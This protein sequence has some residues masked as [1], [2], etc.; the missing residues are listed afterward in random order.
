MSEE[1]VIY[2][3]NARLNI[4]INGQNGDYPDLVSFDAGDG[5]IKQ[6]ATEALRTGYVP[7]IGVIGEPDLRDFVVDRFPAAND[8]PPRLMVRPKTPF[9]AR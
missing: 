7:G 8:L 1:I 6:I 5:D 4:T 3:P 2:G 9:G